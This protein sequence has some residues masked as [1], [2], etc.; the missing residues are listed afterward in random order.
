[1]SSK[2]SNTRTK[3]LDATW[4]LMEKQRGRGVRMSD[5]AKKAGVSR[6]AVY[7]HFDSRVE[8]MSAT[9][10][11]VDEVL[12]LDGRFARVQEAKNAGEALEFFIEVWGTYIPEIYGI[13]KALLAVRDEDK[14]AAAAWDECME[15]LRS[16]SDEIVGGLDREG[17]LSARWDK[18]EAGE[19]LFAMLSIQNWEQLT[20]GCGW[21][22]AGYVEGMA[23]M[24]RRT[25][26]G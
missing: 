10:K 4:K 13:S 22:Q 2:E 25:L 20:L 1:M 21:T 3:I 18:E 12:G 7:L 5:I 11:Y 8:L 9:T 24:L 17:V 19:L 14:A 15:C 23:L 6:Q 26:V 16:A